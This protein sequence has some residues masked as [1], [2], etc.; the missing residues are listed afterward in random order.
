[1]FCVN[2]Q[3]R[4]LKCWSIIFKFMGLVGIVQSHLFLKY[5]FTLI[6]MVVYKKYHEVLFCQGQVVGRHHVPQTHKHLPVKPN[7]LAPK[8]L[9]KCQKLTTALVH[10]MDTGE[11]SNGKSK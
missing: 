5:M 7:S 1:M 4:I 8:F 10:T 2:K 11:L 9:A 6:F 3:Y